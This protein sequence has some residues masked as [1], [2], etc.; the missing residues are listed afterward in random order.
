MQQPRSLWWMLQQEKVEGRTH[1][2]VEE[3]IS[4]AALPSLGW[5]AEG[6]AERPVLARGGVIAEEIGYGN[7]II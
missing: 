1:T 3:E 5:R 6:K 2:F 7:T 4:E